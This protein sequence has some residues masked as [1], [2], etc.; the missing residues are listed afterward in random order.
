MARL[1][2]PALFDQWA[3]SYDAAPNPLRLLEERTLPELLGDVRGLHVIDAGCGTGVRLR[4]LRAQGARAVG[5]DWS[6]K[7]LQASPTA[8][9]QGDLRAPCFQ[10]ESADLVLC[11]FALA[12]APQAVSALAALVRPDGRLVLSDVHPANDWSRGFPGVPIAASNWNDPPGMTLERRLEPSFNDADRPLFGD[13]PDV[14]E[15][16]RR[17]PALQLDCWRKTR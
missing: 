7:M 5:F 2:T 13:R 17:G 11:T 1:P 16:A 3:Q 8:V 12:Y 6:P 9:A 14:L 15:R 4:A 10:D